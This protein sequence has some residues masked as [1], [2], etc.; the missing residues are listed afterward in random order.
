MTNTSSSSGGKLSLMKK[1][2]PSLKPSIDL[3][4]KRSGRVIQDIHFLYGYL[5]MTFIVGLIGL[6]SYLGSN[7]Q[8]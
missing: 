6:S 5:F 8:R 7:I 3:R 2:R 4:P 1:S